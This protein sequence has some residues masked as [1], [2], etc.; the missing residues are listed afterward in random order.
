MSAT[1]FDTIIIG[2]GISGI[3]AAYYMQTD[4]PSQTYTILEGRGNIGGTWDLF[5]YPGIRSDSDM[6]TFGFAFKPWV[7]PK[8]I[9]PRADIMDYLEETV[10]ENGIDKHIRFEHKLLHA[11]WSSD[12]A[13]WS[14]TVQT[15]DSEKSVIFTC[16]FLSLCMGYYNYESGYTPDFA[17]KED[18]KGTVI[19]PQKWDETLDYS[20]K[21]W[22]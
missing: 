6:Y 16:S 12:T 2:A 14:L 10:T 21:K 17:G 1:H 3:S 5:R 7:N 11:T 4:C 9:A 18:Y 13:T 15:P 19:H 20:K 8:V 22:W